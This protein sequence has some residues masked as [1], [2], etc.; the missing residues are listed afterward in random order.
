MGADTGDWLT[1]TRMSYDTVADSYADLTRHLLDETPG[2]R[3]V[4]ASFADLVSRRGGGPVADIG[5][6][7]GRITAHLSGLGLRVRGIDLSPA[8]IDIARREYPGLR[9]DVGSMTD[10]AL[11]ESSLA[12]LVAWYSLIHVPDS[13]IGPVL[14]RFRR[15]L[16]P[17]G[18]LLVGFHV[19]DESRLL[20]RGYG[21]HPMN[22]QVH[23]RPLRRMRGWLEEAGFEIESSRTLVSAESA[24]GGIVLARRRRSAIRG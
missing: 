5:C 8:M 3:A 11:A 23:R 13:E 19:G 6:G 7:S 22:L 4:F 17:G 15:V 21:G 18:P 20:T 10:L 2:E 1:D 24:C 12:G 14:A 16:A 9:F